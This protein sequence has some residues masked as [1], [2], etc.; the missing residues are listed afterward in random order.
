MKAI[1]KKHH[2]IAGAIIGAVLP[3]C[4]YIAV[5]LLD[6][7]VETHGYGS[8]VSVALY[9]IEPIYRLIL[10]PGSVTSNKNIGTVVVVPLVWSTLGYLIGRTA[11]R[12]TSKQKGPPNQAL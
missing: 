9:T 3:I 5:V 6:D 4:L 7:A 1:P 2:G 11:F 12:R 8:L 10:M